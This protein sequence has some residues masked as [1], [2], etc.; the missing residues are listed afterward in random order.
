MREPAAAPKPIRN[1]VMQPAEEVLVLRD[2][3]LRPRLAP[4]VLRVESL[5]D[6]ALLHAHRR[7]RRGRVEGDLPGRLARPHR[8][9]RMVG[10]SRATPA[11]ITGTTRAVA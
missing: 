3:A 11:W 1:D 5:R 7:A 2:H 4:S 6:L 10:A 9:A 8:I